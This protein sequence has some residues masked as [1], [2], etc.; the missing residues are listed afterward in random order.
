[1]TKILGK[2]TGYVLVTS[3]MGEFLD[4]ESYHVVEYDP[5]VRNFENRNLLAEKIIVPDE[6]TEEELV[7]LGKEEFLK[8][9]K[10]KEE[11]EV[12]AEP[13]KSE[14]KKGK[15]AKEEVEAEVE[16]KEEPV[17]EDEAEEVIVD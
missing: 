3:N 11:G 15:K 12:K 9:Y 5:I 2:T 7:A 16:V 4:G 8:K 14:S 1:M 10:V 13:K 6:A 17:Y